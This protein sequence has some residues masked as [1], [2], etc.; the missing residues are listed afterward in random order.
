MPTKKK[1]TTPVRDDEASKD[2]TGSTDTN[3]KSNFMPFQVHGKMRLAPCVRYQL[4]SNELSKLDAILSGDVSESV[5]YLKELKS[6]RVPKKSD[7]TWPT[8]EKVESDDED[9][10]VVGMN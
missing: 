5:T 1:A 3:G 8:E 2:S 6:D 7:K 10:V 9:V 4:S